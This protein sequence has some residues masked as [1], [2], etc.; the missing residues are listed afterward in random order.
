SASAADDECRRRAG[1]WVRPPATASGGADHGDASALVIWRLTSIPRNLVR[2]HCKA[3]TTI[4][5][6][7]QLWS[8]LNSRRSEWSCSENRCYRRVHAVAYC[9]SAVPQF[10]SAALRHRDERP[11]EKWGSHAQIDCF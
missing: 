11:T 4:Q 2:R 1:E 9:C 10:R 6:H 5:K 3:R 8:L 7:F